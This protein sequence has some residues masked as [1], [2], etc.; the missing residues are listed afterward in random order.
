MLIIFF[1]LLSQ[2]EMT[3]IILGSRFLDLSTLLRVENMHS[4]YMFI[5]VKY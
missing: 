3:D 4:F 2:F 5:V 1:C